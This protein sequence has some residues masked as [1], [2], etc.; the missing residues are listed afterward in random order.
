MASVEVLCKYV[1]QTSAP[2]NLV[3]ANTA[4]LNA[5]DDNGAYI[6]SVLGYEIS[7]VLTL[8]PDAGSY[9]PDGATI[10][11]VVTI[12][13][14]KAESDL[15]TLEPMIFAVVNGTGGGEWYDSVSSNTTYDDTQGATAW[16]TPTTNPLGY[17]AASINAGTQTVQVQTANAGVW[18][19]NDVFRIDC[20]K[21]VVYYTAAAAS[22]AAGWRQRNFRGRILR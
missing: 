9:I 20:V 2:D 18:L 3:W 6:T 13:R 15:G 1:S 14:A 12:L 5:Q 7:Q 19:P 8:R 22:A 10:N 21:L 17:S 4:A 11:G 16:G